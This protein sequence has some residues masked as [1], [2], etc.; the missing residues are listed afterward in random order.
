MRSY[1]VF[2]DWD[3]A[4]PA[5]HARQI[6]REAE[7]NSTHVQYTRIEVKG[8]TDTPGT[9]RHSQ[10]VSGR[11]ANA[12][13]T[14]LVCNGVPRN[15]IAICGVGQIHLPVATST[16]VREPQNRRVEIII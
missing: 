16:G 3:K 5:D 6:V 14:E 2:F 4:T 7:V 10:G 8:H 11:G 13:A 15:V 1:L 12:V 9:P